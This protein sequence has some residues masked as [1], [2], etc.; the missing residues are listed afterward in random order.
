MFG[1]FGAVLEQGTQLLAVLGNHD[2]L[3]G[4]GPAQ[5]EALGMDGRWW[6]REF[7]DLLVIGLDSND[8]ADPS[9]R[10][11]RPHVGHDARARWKIVAL[12]HPP[13]SAG[14]Q[15]SQPRYA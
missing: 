6:Q 7:G 5:L 15:G 10:V 11:P 2:V 14:Y 1:P 4:H 12:H 3:D 9:A 8:L 13:Y